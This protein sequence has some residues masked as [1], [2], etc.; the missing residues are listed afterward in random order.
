MIGVAHLPHQVMAQGEAV[1]AYIGIGLE[2]HVASPTQFLHIR[3]SW[4]RVTTN[5]KKGLLIIP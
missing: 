5:M 4:R 3:T 2:L 1:I